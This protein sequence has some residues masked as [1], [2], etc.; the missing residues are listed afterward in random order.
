MF[1]KLEEASII[2]MSASTESIIDRV[3][4]ECPEC[5]PEF[6]RILDALKPCGVREDEIIISTMTAEEVD[7]IILMH[8]LRQGH[9]LEE[10]EE[11]LPLMRD[12]F[13]GDMVW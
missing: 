6:I 7:S 8:L 12:E 4:R 5:L 9:T 13:M 3:R 11:L 2:Y 1:K 10:A